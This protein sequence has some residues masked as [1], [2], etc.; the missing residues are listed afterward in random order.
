MKHS[1]AI[2]KMQKCP[3]AFYLSKYLTQMML[4]NGLR[5]LQLIHFGSKP[6]CSRYK[7]LIPIPSHLTPNRFL[8]S[9]SHI[10]CC[11]LEVNRVMKY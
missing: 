8:S 7:A 2:R 3:N 6:M 1:T 10:Y 4:G 9:S 5:F 11:W